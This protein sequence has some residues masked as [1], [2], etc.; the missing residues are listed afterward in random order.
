VLS[1]KQGHHAF[2]STEQEQEHNI[3]LAHQKGLL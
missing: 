2:S 1:D 3:A